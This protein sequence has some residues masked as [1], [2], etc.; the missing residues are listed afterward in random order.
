MK[1]L[2]EQ[3]EVMTH[4]LNGGEVEAITKNVQDS[5]WVKAPF[6][7]WDWNKY[8]Y[9]IKEEKQKITIEKWLCLDKADIKTN[10]FYILEA[11]KEYLEKY[12]KD[13]EKIKLL[14]SYEVDTGSTEK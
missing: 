5:S 6:P 11:T 3:I 9:S 1:T 12:V 7:C 4:F 2:K 10:R 13:D 14:D 8:D